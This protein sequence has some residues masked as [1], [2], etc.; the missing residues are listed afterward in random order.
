[1]TLNAA[2]GGGDIAGIL[3]CNAG[4]AQVAIGV[5]CACCVDAQGAAGGDVARIDD[6]NAGVGGPQR[7]GGNAV[8]AGVDIAGIVDGDGAV[9]ALGIG[10]GE[11]SAAGEVDDVVVAA[12]GERYGVVVRIAIAGAGVGIDANDRRRRHLEDR[13]WPRSRAAGAGRGLRDGRGRREQRA[14]E[15]R[16]RQ[17]S[18]DEQRGAVCLT[19]SL[20]E[21]RPLQTAARRGKTRINTR[22]CPADGARSRLARLSPSLTHDRS[23]PRPLRADP[24]SRNL[25][26]LAV[27]RTGKAK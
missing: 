7:P 3:D 14:D 12:R 6:G 27:T 24:R 25:A 26:R 4:V 8:A 16:R 22:T 10:G 11:R 2:Q 20:Q 15:E 1:M 21:M 19:G 18:A 13:G 5:S 17:R 23:P 9:A